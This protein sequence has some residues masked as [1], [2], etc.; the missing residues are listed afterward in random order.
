MAQ[1][2]ILTSDRVQTALRVV[3]QHARLA[4]AYLF[5]SQVSGTADR[6]S[7][8]DLAVFVEGVESWSLHD[9]AR[10]AADVQREAGDDVE[11]HLMPAR[12]LTEHDPA[13]FAA[14][15]LAHGVEVPVPGATAGE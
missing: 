9:R 8:T 7:D 11:V 13:S 14:W 1:P 5:G 6:W 3:A 4:R 15:V 12:M 2:D 10:L